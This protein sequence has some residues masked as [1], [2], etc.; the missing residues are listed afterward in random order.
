MHQKIPL[1]GNGQLIDILFFMP[2]S[3]TLRPLSGIF[4]SRPEAGAKQTRS[5]GEGRH[6]MK[7]VSLKVHENILGKPAIAP[8]QVC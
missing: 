4:R 6:V 8:D 3:L 2:C 1:C 7:P 5:K